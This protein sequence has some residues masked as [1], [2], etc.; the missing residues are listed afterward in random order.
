MTLRDFNCLSDA[1]KDEVV[2]LWGDYFT[3]NVVP[4]YRVKVYKL[5]DFY[6][7]VYFDSKTDRIK[8]FRGCTNTKALLGA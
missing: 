1:G 5:D 4:G 7:E 6:V 2:M 3:E 8:K